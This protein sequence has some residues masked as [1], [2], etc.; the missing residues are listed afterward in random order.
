VDLIL[1]SLERPV[2]VALRHLASPLHSS[3]LLP[4]LRGPACPSGSASEAQPWLP[5]QGPSEGGGLGLLEQ[6]PRRNE[7]SAGSYTPVGQKLAMSSP[8]C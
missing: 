3:P 2:Y 4:T 5:G 6:S 8:T 7:R 1:Y